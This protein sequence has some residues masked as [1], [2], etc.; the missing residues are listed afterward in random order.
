M[1]SDLFAVKEVL[2]VMDE[3][4]L[5]DLGTFMISK[6]I[7]QVMYAMGRQ[8]YRGSPLDASAYETMART[9][10]RFCQNFRRIKKS[11]SPG[12]VSWKLW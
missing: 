7:G 4:K 5:I 9:S 11:G 8:G 12:T 6:N 3:G 1:T 2:E 10:I